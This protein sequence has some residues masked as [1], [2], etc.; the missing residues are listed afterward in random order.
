[1]EPLENNEFK[2]EQ[3]VSFTPTL[4]QKTERRNRFGIII[5]NIGFILIFWPFALALIL[6][7]I[8]APFALFGFD[9]IANKIAYSALISIFGIY[10]VI[11]GI[12]LALIAAYI[13]NKEAEAVKK[14][15]VLTES[16]TKLKQKIRIVWVFGFSPLLIFTVDQL[17]T[18][19]LNCHVTNK[20]SSCDTGGESMAHLLH[21]VFFATPILISLTFPIALFTVHFLTKK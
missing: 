18:Y 3:A 10:T 13:N 20:I 12:I 7:V 21:N 4:D 6:M 19:L 8:A 5:G 1:M 17:F 11:P 2:T 9:E 14:D 16:A 15:I